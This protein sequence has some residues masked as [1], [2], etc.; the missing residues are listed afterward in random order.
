MKAIIL[1]SLA[2]LC[3]AIQ[4]KGSIERIYSEEGLES[5][6]TQT[7]RE[8]NLTFKEDLGTHSEYTGWWIF[9]TEAMVYNTHLENIDFGKVSTGTFDSQTMKYLFRGG[10]FT[11]DFH[12]SWEYRF[13]IFPFT[14]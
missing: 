10:P 6:Y 5:F 9:G 8:A 12:Y 1:V 3:M 11:A 2:L 13:F 14:H 4:P 7:F